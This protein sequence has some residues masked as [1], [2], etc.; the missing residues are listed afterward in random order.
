MKITME[1]RL[2]QSWNTCT[3]DDD[4]EDTSLEEVLEI[5]ERCLRGMGYSFKG[6]LDCVS[7]W[8]EVEEEALRRIEAEEDLIH[9][10]GSDEIG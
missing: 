2:G 8:T 9:T 7:D 10:S 1:G 3:V 5:C 6:S 4:S